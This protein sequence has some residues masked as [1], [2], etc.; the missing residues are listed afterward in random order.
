MAL[1]LV[2]D[3]PDCCKAAVA[4]FVEDDETIG[5]AA[6]SS[7]GQKPPGP[8]LDGCSASTSQPILSEICEATVGRR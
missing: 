5:D 8:Y 3:Q 7:M 6:P 1:F 2:T 4:E